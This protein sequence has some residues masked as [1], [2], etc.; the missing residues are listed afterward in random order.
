MTMMPVLHTRTRALT[1]YT[2]PFVN[3]IILFYLVFY[4]ICQHVLGSGNCL[5]STLIA[6]LQ[7][8]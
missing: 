1:S 2:Q 6:L 7:L 3:C 5:N 4:L 8:G